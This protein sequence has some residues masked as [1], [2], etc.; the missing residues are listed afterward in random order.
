MRLYLKGRAKKIWVARKKRE[1]TI[2]RRVRWSWWSKHD[3]LALSSYI[4]KK[5]KQLKLFLIKIM[6]TLPLTEV[7]LV[8][9][10][11]LTKRRGRLISSIFSIKILILFTPAI[12]YTHLLYPCITFLWHTLYFPLHMHSPIIRLIICF[13]RIIIDI[14]V[15]RR[16]ERCVL[17]LE[18]K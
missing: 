7:P 9:P 2:T 18:G 15:Y 14:I 17:F 10:K 16:K 8:M 1:E 12:S 13:R 6:A 11:N 4:Y 3:R 5:L